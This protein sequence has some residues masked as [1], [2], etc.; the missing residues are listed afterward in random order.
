MFDLKTIQNRTGS[1]ERWLGRP[2]ERS[3]IG[4]REVSSRMHEASRSSP[5]ELH[6][7]VLLDE[8][9]VVRLESVHVR[10]VY[11][12]HASVYI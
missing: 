3:D 11:T 6:G 8:A 7:K 9:F 4:Q 5:L 1:R 10:H 2:S 12:K